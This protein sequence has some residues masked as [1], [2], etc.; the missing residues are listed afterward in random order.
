MSSFV[1]FFFIRIRFSYFAALRDCVFMCFFG[2]GMLGV[3]RSPGGEGWGASW[4][5]RASLAGQRSLPRNLD[6]GEIR[7]RLQDHGAGTQRDPPVYEKGYAAGD[8]GTWG[9]PGGIACDRR[10]FLSSFC[11]CLVKGGF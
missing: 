4:G 10:Q 9:Y 1:R 2:G 7:E 8:C 3:L 11:N 5:S 6:S